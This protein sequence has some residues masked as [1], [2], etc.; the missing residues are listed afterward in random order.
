M[1]LQSVR[2]FLAEHAPDLEILEKS[3]STATVAEAAEAHGVRPGQIAKTLSFWLK[4][5]IV[6]LSRRH[7]R[8]FAIEVDV[9]ATSSGEAY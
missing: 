4:D 9:I 5:E 2:A 1:S 6:L 8:E 3:T 7:P